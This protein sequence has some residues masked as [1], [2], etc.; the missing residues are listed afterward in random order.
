M[1]ILLDRP[2]TKHVEK[3]PDEAS[4]ATAHDVAVASFEQWWW[5]LSAHDQIAALL[6]AIGEY[7]ALVHGAIWATLLGLF[8][9]HGQ[10]AG[11]SEHSRLVL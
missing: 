1:A 11:Q 3:Q 4:I 10:D 7:G 8:G 2:P 5:R 9:D 6:F